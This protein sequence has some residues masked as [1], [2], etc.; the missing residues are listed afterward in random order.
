[1]NPVAYPLVGEIELI[2]EV[3]SSRDKNASEI[4]PRGKQQAHS[5]ICLNSE[6][7]RVK[8]EVERK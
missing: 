7:S 2:A 6:A 4:T 5:I 3:I 8:V 1:M